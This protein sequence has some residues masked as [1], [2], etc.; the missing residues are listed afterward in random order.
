[1]AFFSLSVALSVLGVKP[2]D[3]RQVSFAADRHTA[4]VLQRA[5]PRGEVLRK[6]PVC[7]RGGIAGARI[8]AQRD[9]R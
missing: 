5:S 8:Q 3:L 4:H 1:M 6:Y 9:S 7:V 2:A